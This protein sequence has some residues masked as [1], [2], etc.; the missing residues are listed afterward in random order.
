MNQTT[1][2]DRATGRRTG[3]GFGR[4][5]VTVYGVLAFAAIGR[6]SY[7]LVV[8]FHEAPVAYSLS[9]LAAVVYVVATFALA[10]GTPVWRTVAWVTVGIEA[11]GVVTVGALSL[12]DPGVFGESTVWSGF[13][14]GYGYVPLVLP[15]VGLWWL[16]RT[17]HSTSARTSEERTA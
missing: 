3:R 2:P 6:S 17:K 15:F 9:T 7:E 14:Q 10:I 4:V 11:V 13:G 1:G 5:L 12:A 16:W 8:K